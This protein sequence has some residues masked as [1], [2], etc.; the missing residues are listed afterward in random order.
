[1]QLSWSM[2]SCWTRSTTKPITWTC[3]TVLFMGQLPTNRI[4]GKEAFSKY[5]EA[6]NS[7]FSL[8]NAKLLVL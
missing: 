3:L 6:S 1:M 4:S 5:D 8:C 2:L 7:S